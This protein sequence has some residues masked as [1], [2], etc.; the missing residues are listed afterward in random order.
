MMYV[1]FSR[2][3]L[4][5]KTGEQLLLSLSMAKVLTMLPESV[6]VIH[7][8]FTNLRYISQKFPG[9]QTIRKHF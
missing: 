3:V 8:F 7:R 9:K 2:T 1:K 6:A 5:V 4:L